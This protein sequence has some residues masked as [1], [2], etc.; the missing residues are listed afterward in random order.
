V[1]QVNDAGTFGG[2][3]SATTDEDTAISGTVTFTDLADGFTTPNFTVSSG[4]IVG[5]AVMDAAGAWSYTPNGNF[6]G[7]DSFVVSVTD[8]DGNVETQLISI[9]VTP[10]ND[11]L[12]LDDNFAID[13]NTTLN[14]DVSTNDST[15]SGGMLDFVVDTDVSN[16]TLVLNSNGSFTY[17]PDLNF[18]GSETFT[19][20]V[21]DPA[22]GE[23]LTTQ[24][25]LTPTETSMAMTS[26]LGNEV[27][28]HLPV[29]RYLTAMQM[30][31]GPSTDST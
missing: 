24:P 7:S 4:I 26:L 5:T 21:S 20:I 23:S 22:S 27:S 17:D 12:A 15:T 16:G 11:L 28:V 19:Y 2:D 25:T 29:Q 1:T 30:V 31:M 9:T 10:I 8:D 13:E 18:N 14:G 3:L 6:N